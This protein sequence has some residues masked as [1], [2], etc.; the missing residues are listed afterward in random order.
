MKKNIII[1]TAILAL[2]VTV[3]GFTTV[4]AS[5]GMNGRTGSMRAILQTVFAIGDS[6]KTLAKDVNLTDA[7]KGQIKAIVTSVKPQ[8]EDLHKQLETKRKELRGVLLSA[9]PDQAQLQALTQDI[10]NINSQLT[11]FRI[12]TATQIT[13]VLTPEQKQLALKDL[14]EIDPL[15]DQL[16][17]EIH[18]MAMNSKMLK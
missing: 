3:I 5:E 4:F 17:D 14:T 13:Q 16:K 1:S 7:Q 11:V 18:A 2:L 15:I 8:A 12:Q 10:A 9:N 6:L